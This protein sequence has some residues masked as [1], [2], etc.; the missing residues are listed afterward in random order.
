V[1]RRHDAIRRLIREHDLAT[2]AEIADALRAE[3]FDVVQTTV[4]RDIRDLGLVK[5]RAPSG[6]LVY[7][8]APG[9]DVDALRRALRSFALS[10]EATGPLVVIQTPSGHANALARPIDES[11]HPNVAGTVAGDNTVFVAAREPATGA[12][13]RDRLL[14]LAEEGAA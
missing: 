13:L 4:S 10:I 5:V 12:Q 9:P 11:N 7:A 14:A 2:Q 3:G 6:R 1:K 8:S